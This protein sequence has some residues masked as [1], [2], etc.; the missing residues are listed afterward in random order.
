LLVL[1]EENFK[2]QVKDYQEVKVQE[3]F[4]SL[5]NGALPKSCTVILEDD[6]VDICKPGD[7]V[8][9]KLFLNAIFSSII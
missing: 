3:K 8:T 4:E 1:I 7:N 2:L 5:I 6:L 9:I